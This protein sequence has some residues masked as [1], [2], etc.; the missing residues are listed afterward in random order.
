[1]SGRI[2]TGIR[3]ITWHKL[4]DLLLFQVGNK[5]LIIA[6]TAREGNG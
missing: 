3:V 1:M 6:K 5:L 2:R 4:D